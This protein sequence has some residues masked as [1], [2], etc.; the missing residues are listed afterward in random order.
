M[1]SGVFWWE[2]EAALKR[3]PEGQ[4]NSPVA[5]GQPEGQLN[6]PVACGQPEGQ[7]TSVDALWASKA[8]SKTVP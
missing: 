3:Q 7:L 4:L 2:T 5:C 8:Q 6:S 1:L